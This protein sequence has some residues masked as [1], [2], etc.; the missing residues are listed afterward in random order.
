MISPIVTELFIRERKLHISTVFIET[1]EDQGKKQVEVL[2]ILKVDHQLSINDRIPKD[3][4]SKEAQNEFDKIEEI[5]K[6]ANR[7][8]LIY[9]TDKY[10]YNLRQFEKI[11]S[12]DRNIN[13]TITYEADKD[14][15]NSL[16]EIIN[17]RK[18]VR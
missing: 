14:E 9:K 2:K 6:R 11:K 13:K 16:M 12:F 17:F 3:H 1:I 8:K 10:T 7:E 4:L 15:S 5:G 18:N